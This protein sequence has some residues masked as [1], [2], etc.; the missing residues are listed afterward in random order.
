MGNQYAYGNYVEGQVCFQIAECLRRQLNDFGMDAAMPTT[1]E[2]TFQERVKHSNLWG[3]DLHICIHTNAGGGDGT[4]VFCHPK[5]V[6]DAYVKAIYN[7]VAAL[8]PGD[9]D[10]IRAMT[11]LYEINKTTAKCVYV[12]VEFHDDTEQA[13]WIV[14]HTSE[15]AYAIAQAIANTAGVEHPTYTSP[16]PSKPMYFVRKEFTSSAEAYKVAK[17]IRKK[18][19]DAFMAEKDGVAYVQTG[20]FYSQEKAKNYAGKLPMEGFEVL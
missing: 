8:S 19:A 5:N 9:D 18:G 15:I 3:A 13:K 2:T 7:S 16:N 4:V 10:G 20:A 6:E 14:E 12:E 11:D 1:P 17:A